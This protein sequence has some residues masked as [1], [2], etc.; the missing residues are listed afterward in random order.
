MLRKG[1]A[2][3]RTTL[4][5]QKLAP[6]RKMMKHVRKA[7]QSMTNLWKSETPVEHSGTHWKTIHCVRASGI[8]KGALFP[9]SGPV[10]HVAASRALDK[11]QQ[12]HILFTV[13]SLPVSFTLGFSWFL[14]G[15]QPRRLR[16]QALLEVWEDCCCGLVQH[17]WHIILTS[18]PH[19][20]ASSK[21]PCQKYPKVV[22]NAKKRDHRD[23]VIDCTVIV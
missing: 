15:F 18:L 12:V 23:L 11:A 21:H 13:S 19:L 9:W 4:R 10:Q 2:W 14:Y 3:R 20:P 6:A 22:S 1:T 5:L 17:C 8:S 7:Y 16:L